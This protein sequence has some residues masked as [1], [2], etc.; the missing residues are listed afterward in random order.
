[1]KSACI[2]LAVL[3]LC[4][5]TTQAQSSSSDDPSK[6]LRRLVLPDDSDQPK[7]IHQYD[8]FED[9]TRYW[10]VPLTVSPG[11]TFAVQLSYK[12][13]GRGHEVEGFYFTFQSASDDWR[14]LKNARLYCLLDGSP[15]DLG[16]PV[17]R[18]NDVKTTDDRVEV[19]EL[20]MFATTYQR[21]KVMAA[22]KVIE[23]RLGTTQ[24][25]LSSDFRDS[26]Q[27]LLKTVKTVK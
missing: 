2:L 21:L 1:M 8:R 14:Y 16:I 26:L 11:V 5:I 27:A 7:T 22:A 25:T 17:A 19:K 9:R 12:G 18:D 23:M 24:F 6:E 4:A 20:F 13:Q 3:T 15:V 10:T